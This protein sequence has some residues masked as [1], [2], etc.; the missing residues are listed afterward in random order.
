MGRSNYASVSETLDKTRRAAADMSERMGERIGSMA[1]E[2]ADS[3]KDMAYGAS[4]K[5]KRV[6]DDVADR[7]KRSAGDVA[8]GTDR[9]MANASDLGNR[10]VDQAQSRASQTLAD[11]ERF[12][13][14]N[15]VGAVVAALGIGVVLG[16]MTRK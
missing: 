6:A 9:L 5:V 3:V 13:A 2:A 10:A 4:E 15:P 14:R 11:V 12:V 8:E 1:D 7:V 16:F